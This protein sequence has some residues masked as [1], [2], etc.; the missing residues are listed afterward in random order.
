M[1]IQ[2]TIPEF[3]SEVAYI[4]IIG[5]RLKEVLCD[6]YSLYIIHYDLAHE[7][8]S[9]FLAK[10]KSDKKY[11]IAIHIGN[12]HAYNSRLYDYFDLVFR[13][14]HHESCDYIKV[15]PIN[16]GFNSSGKNDVYPI[17]GPKLSERKTNVF[18]SGREQHRQAEKQILEK[19][20]N[21]YDIQ[22]TKSFRTGL[23]IEEYYKKLADTKICLVPTG[24]SS[25]TFR[26]T[27]AHGSGCIVI[28]KDR[29][30]VW[31]Y[32]DTPAIFVDD[33]SQVTDEFIKAILKTNID[34]WYVKNLHYYDK[35]LSPEATAL[36]IYNTIIRC[37]VKR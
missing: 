26:Y 14:Y 23:S 11:K 36:Y 5:E 7:E 16:I 9:N 22:F 24:L 13:F 15:F 8:Y 1:I 4:K 18:F 31:F 2:N 25:E 37:G 19:L 35:Y 27:E 6:D 21:K 32:H 17:R 20:S 10:V 28:T 33:W 34:K 3:Y 29:P 12:E 30:K